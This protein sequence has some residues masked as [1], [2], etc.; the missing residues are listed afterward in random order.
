MEGSMTFLQGILIAE[1]A[2]FLWLITKARTIGNKLLHLVDFVD[3]NLLFLFE[4]QIGLWAI[5][6]LWLWVGLESIGLPM[7][8][9]EF[10]G[11]VFLVGINAPLIIEQIVGSLG[12]LHKQPVKR[13]DE[14]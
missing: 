8:K 3:E 5:M 1:I 14:K 6:L 13:G 12:P 2:W 11:I 4:S 9:G 10:N 7:P